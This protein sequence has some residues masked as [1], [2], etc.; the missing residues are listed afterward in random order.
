MDANQE[1][2]STAAGS[3][4]ALEHTLW[5]VAVALVWGSTNPLLKKG[6]AGIE[7][8]HYQNRALQLVAELKF[9]GLNWRYMVP[10]LLNQSGSLIYYLTIGRAEIS[11]AVPITNSLTFLV[12]TVVGRLL[13]EKT[14]SNLTY[15]GI[16]LVLC[17]ITLC[18]LS[19]VS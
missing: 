11:L 13:G 4:S 5:F 1:A 12:T 14:Q 15:L 19:K 16:A 10:F 3:T 17:G 7:K 8:I 2:A 6:S 18:V 9:L